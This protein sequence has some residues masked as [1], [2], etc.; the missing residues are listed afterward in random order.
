MTHAHCMLDA[1]ATHTH[2]EY[3]IPVAFPGKQ[4][5]YDRPSGLRY[6]YTA[7]L[8]TVKTSSTV[9]TVKVLFRSLSVGGTEIRLSRI[10]I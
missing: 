6:T 4:W 2:S 5:L 9:Q 1:K 10:K 3:V 7:C 8:V